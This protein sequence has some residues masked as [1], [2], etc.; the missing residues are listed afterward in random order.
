M[1]LVAGVLWP[2][3]SGAPRFWEIDYCRGIAVVMMIVFHSAFDIAYFGVLDLRVQSGPWKLLAVC[4]A[5]LFLLLVGISLTISSAR[6]RKTLRK[7]DYLCKYLRRGAGIMGLGFILTLVTL[8]MVPKEPI[9]FG[10]LHLIGLLVMLAPLYLR[11]TWANLFSG[12]GVIATGWWIGGLNGPAWLIWL[13]VYPQGFASLD[14][15][16]VFPWAGAVLLGVWLGHL[17]YPGG[18]RRASAP[19]AKLPARE[20]LCVAGRHSLVIYLL[21]QPAILCI[22]SIIWFPAGI[23]H[24]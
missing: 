24:M 8:V 3:P 10:I 9:F 22:I 4:T 1:N 23:W 5:S 17:L 18:E 19:V 16:P 14:Y 6:A 20:I 7:G 13:G 12:L 21:H 11:Y 15:T 2:H